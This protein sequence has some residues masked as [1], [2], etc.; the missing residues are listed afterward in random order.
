MCDLSFCND[1]LAMLA[2]RLFVLLFL[3]ALFIQSGSD[4]VFGWKGNLEWLKGHFAASFLRSSV[5]L[6]LFVITVFEVLAGL[7]LLTG[8][9]LL[10]ATGSYFVA[11]A[12]L[13]FGAL[14]LLCLFT[15]QRIAKD[16]P[17]AASLVP[18]FIL[19]LLGLWFFL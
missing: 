4:K 1:N 14:A 12:G 8:A 11:K 17:G 13:A 9:I 10:L 7:L 19:T 5:P 18:Y 2:I 3:A 15:G 16:Y 6:L